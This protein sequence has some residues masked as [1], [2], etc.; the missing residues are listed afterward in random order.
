M[1]T[2]G[3]PTSQRTTLSQHVN[4]PLANFFL[5]RPNRTE[6]PEH[7]CANY[8]CYFL[9]SL[10]LSPLS[11]QCISHTHYLSLSHT[12]SLSPTHTLCLSH[13]LSLHTPS[14]HGTTVQLNSR[15]SFSKLGCVV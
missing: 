4:V 13:T 2:P 5:R 3:V 9:S 14:F 7:L 8:L 6:K 11:S 12:L 15:C 1:N 10:S